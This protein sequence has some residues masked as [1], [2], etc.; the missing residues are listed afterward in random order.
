[1]S[2]RSPVQGDQPSPG[3]TLQTYNPS[4]VYMRR[5][6]RI[7]VFAMGQITAR[8]DVAAHIL[9]VVV[10]CGKCQ[11]TEPWLGICATLLLLPCSRSGHEVKSQAAG[12]GGIY[13]RKWPNPGPRLVVNREP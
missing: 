10:A 3:F 4:F 7:W 11:V 6:R 5:P 1:M 12:R 8:S 13:T 9:G 2:H